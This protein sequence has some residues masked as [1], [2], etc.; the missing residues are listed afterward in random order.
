MNSKIISF[1]ILLCILT[2]SCNPLEKLTNQVNTDLP[3]EL[4]N[5]FYHKDLVGSYIKNPEDILGKL[6]YVYRIN[7][8][9]LIYNF[10]VLRYPQLLGTLNRDET[11]TLRASGVIEYKNTNDF[12]LFLSAFNLNTAT[13]S[14]EAAEIVVIDNKQ[15]S[16]NGDT[17]QTFF[18]TNPKLPIE[19]HKELGKN[20]YPERILYIRGVNITAVSSKKAKTFSNSTEASGAFFKMNNKYYTSGAGFTFDYKAGLTVDDITSSVLLGSNSYDIPKKE[21]SKT[22]NVLDSLTNKLPKSDIKSFNLKKLK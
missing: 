3:S 5:R 22:L 4:K 15:L 13:N 21:E 9:T 18:R 10:S 8:S 20:Y 11:P 19:T 7:D 14:S 2:F 16:I 12:G 6:I 17:I 1:C